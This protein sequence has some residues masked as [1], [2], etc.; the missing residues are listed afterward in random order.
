MN[1]KNLNELI[2][3]DENRFRP[4]VLINDPGYRM[5]L[6]T[7]RA[8]QSV[9]E[10][11]TAGRVTVY[12]IRGRVNFYEGQTACDL[13]QGEVLSV[14]AAAKH[15]VEAVKDSALLVLATLTSPNV[16]DSSDNVDISSVKNLRP[17][18][19]E[20]LDLREVPRPQ[21]HPMIF[22]KFDALAAGE[23]LRLLNDHDPIPLN[24]Q[25]DSIRPGEAS[26][27]YIERG[28]S[29]F[30]IRIRRIAPAGQRATG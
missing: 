7:M 30:R 16:V 13:Q 4:N 23:S 24:R 20:E 18:N 12:V 3:F 11:A 1:K 25:F 6:L 10:H 26:W 22:A 5:V 2:E 27:E 19:D 28:P 15:R 9:P 14:A 29:L 21:R 8:G 17:A